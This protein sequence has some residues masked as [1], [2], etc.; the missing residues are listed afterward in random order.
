M[1]PEEANELYSKTITGLDPHDRDRFRALVQAKMRRAAHY[2]ASY[3][4]DWIEAVSEAI[5]ISQ[6]WVPATERRAAIE[7]MDAAEEEYNDAIE[8]QAVMDAASGT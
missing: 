8:A 3:D 1:T 2:P 6:S 7:R 4:E 5:V